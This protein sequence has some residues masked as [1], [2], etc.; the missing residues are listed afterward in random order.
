MRISNMHTSPH[1]DQWVIYF[2]QSSHIVG[3]PDAMVAE[4]TVA[5]LHGTSCA[6]MVPP[7]APVPLSEPLFI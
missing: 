3:M 7:L 6:M 4:G 5:L 2:H 1:H